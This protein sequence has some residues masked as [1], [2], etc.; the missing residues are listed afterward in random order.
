MKLYVDGEELDFPEQPMGSIGKVVDLGDRLVVS[1]DTGTRSAL[2]VRQGDTILISYRGR[3]YSVTRTKA[4]A[5]Q[6]A[7]IESG[8]IRA[9]MP[10]QIV[11]VRVTEGDPVTTGQV[12][13]VLE[14]MKTQQPFSAPFDGRVE[15][16]AVQTGQIVP[17][18]AFLLKVVP[19]DET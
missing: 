14:A 9:P 19:S 18:G 5:R 7:G 6:A 17:E 16:L 1:T 13:V 4:R 3:Q 11:D 8:E 15:S 12:L 10:G 2:A